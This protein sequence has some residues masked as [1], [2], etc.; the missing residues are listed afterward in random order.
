MWDTHEDKDPSTQASKQPREGL[1][2]VSIEAKC[3]ST[4]QVVRVL[5]VEGKD[6]FRCFW[7][8]AMGAPAIGSFGKASGS[9]VVGLGVETFAGNTV[10]VMINGKVE[11][12]K[13]ELTECKDLLAIN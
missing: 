4:N 2:F 5:S 3:L 13:A 12:V 1:V 11:G 10:T 8:Q 6:F 7:R 9:Y